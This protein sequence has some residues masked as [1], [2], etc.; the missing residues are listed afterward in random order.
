VEID[1]VPHRKSTGLTRLEPCALELFRPPP[2][3]ALDFCLIDK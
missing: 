2:L 3:N 1:I